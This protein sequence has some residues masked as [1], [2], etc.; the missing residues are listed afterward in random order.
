ML[1][2]NAPGGREDPTAALDEQALLLTAEAILE[3]T[4][5]LTTPTGTAMAVVDDSRSFWPTLIPTISGESYEYRTLPGDTLDGLAGRFGVTAAEIQSTTGVVGSGLLETDLRLIIPRNLNVETAAQ[6]LLPDAE[7][8]YSGTAEE[9]DLERTIQEAGGYLTQHHEMVED[10]FELTGAEI[11]QRVASELSVNPRLLL[12]LVEYRSGWLYE[13]PPGAERER[14]PIGFRIPDR[15]GL[16]EELKIAA[17]HLNRAYYGWRA[18]SF[19]LLRFEDG[20]TLRLDPTLNAGSVALMHL[21]A[22]LSNQQAW[23]DHLYAPYGFPVRY[24]NLFG[25][26]WSRAERFG[27]VLP[28]ELEQPTL[29]LPFLPYEGWS[30]TAGPHYAWNSGTPL[31]ALDFSP[32]TLDEPCEPSSVWVTASAEGL[33]VRA[34]DHAVALDLDGDGNEGTG[35]VVVYYH[36]AERDMIPEGNYLAV[37]Q[38]IG[39][40]SCEG[41]TASG[42]HVHIAR[43]YNGEWLAA[44]DIV[45]FILGGWQAIAGERIYLGQLILGEQVVTADPAGRAGSTILR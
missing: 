27:A 24:F 39:H 35:W 17:T 30:L 9:F 13:Y 6:R 14:Y 5:R 16:F 7:L 33:V 19:T 29:E 10:E 40:P 11:I 1:A 37:D 15:Q 43:K 36:I 2:C 3:A 34:R 31:G 38:R 21:F 12:A 26:A 25:D 44:D 23:E 42:T 18:G 28:S 22:L 32:I 8:V 4:A 20:G 41:G 45:P